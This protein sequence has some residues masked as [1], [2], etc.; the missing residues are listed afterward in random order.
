MS[1]KIIN[2][3]FLGIF[4]NFHNLFADQK[5]FDAVHFQKQIDNARNALIV[6]KSIID[7][8]NVVIDYDELNKIPEGRFTVFR[9]DIRLESLFISNPNSDE[10]MVVLAGARS[11][12]A[13]KV[14]DLPQLSM[15]SWVKKLGVNY[16]YIED[17]MYYIHKNLLQGWYYDSGNLIR[18]YVSEYIAK[19][20][21]L[22]QIKQ[23]KIKI[24][25]FSAGGTAAI[26]IGKRVVGCSAIA[27][28]PQINFKDYGYS[29]K[30]KEIT[31]FDIIA[32]SEIGKTNDVLFNLTNNTSKFFLM[33]NARSAYD[34]NLHLKHLVKRFNFNPK[35]GLNFLSENLVLWIYDAVGVSDPHSAFPTPT[36]I[37]VL[38]WATN[39]MQ[40]GM[41]LHKYEEL[42]LSFNEFYFTEFHYK[43]NIFNLEQKR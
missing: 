34:V 11:R 41:D 4:P 1:N 21:D 25:G 17:P 27:I 35:L 22:K 30:F 19:I 7:N 29:K 10:L 2:N 12:G 5:D 31:K 9:D 6:D 8:L 43:K 37:S 36:F 14:A 40:S 32:E 16:L 3:E 33:I 23:S 24:Y 38:L 26:D 39:L 42:F 20:A 28:N 18:T 13:N 15:W